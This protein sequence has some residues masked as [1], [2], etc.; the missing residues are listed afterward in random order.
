MNTLRGS[1]S[2]VAIAS[3]LPS[4]RLTNEEL[5]RRFGEK[6][7]ASITKMAGISERRVV[8]NGQCASDLALTAAER[9]F[10]NKPF[11]RNLIDALIFVSQ[12]PDYRIPPTASVLHGKLGLKED[13]ATFDINQACSAYPYVLSVA[14]SMVTAG[15]ASHVL[16]LNADALSTLIHPGDR[17]LVTLHGDAA[18]ASVV[19]R[20]QEGYGFDGFLLGSDGSGAKH[21]LVL[22]GGARRPSSPETRVERIDDSGCVRTDEHL[23]MDGPAVFHFSVYKVPSVI[24]AALERFQLT[25][26][27]IDAVMLH[28]ANKTMMDLIYK[29][30]R[31]PP[32]KRFYCLERM[33][34]SSGPSTPVALSE[35]WRQQRI[36][37]GSRTLLCSFGAGLTWGVAIIRWPEDAEPSIPL[38]PV[39]PDDEVLSAAI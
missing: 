18:C 38:D 13:C 2:I 31:V 6:E 4:K 28:Q 25:L 22:A 29:S 34:N 11:D 27:D 21:L 3:A 5:A 14:H 8:S 23:F 37:P 9:L 7:L 30:L 36:R 19:G 16:V 39:I 20:C 24:K 12:T 15:V 17:S 26:N 10:K 35:A 32:E 33:G 1:T